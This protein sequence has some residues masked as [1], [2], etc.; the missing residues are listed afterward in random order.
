M[1]L[2][3]AVNG[4]SPCQ[5]VYQKQQ[6]RVSNLNAKFEQNN[7]S[8]KSCARTTGQTARS[9]L[10]SLCNKI[11]DYN[12]LNCGHNA[13]YAASII[14]EE[15]SNKLK[16]VVY[17]HH[18]F[19]KLH[20]DYPDN[21]Q[22]EKGYDYFT[23]AF[24]DF[25]ILRI[26]QENQTSPESAAKLEE[27]LNFRDSKDYNDLKLKDFDYLISKFKQEPE[28]AKKYKQENSAYSTIALL[29][30]RDYD[31]ELIDKL[32]EMK[33]KNPKAL[34]GL[35]RQLISYRIKNNIGP[36]LAHIPEVVDYVK[37]VEIKG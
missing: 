9:E 10:N 6:K 11:Y 4:I 19:P 3:S 12:W 34:E 31:P 17:K 8:F 21:A 25:A 18:H 1:S 35:E 26:V 22:P 32:Y 29:M 13:K 2:I 16:G 15:L 27:Y 36:L 23:R 20:H 37:S 30:A 24:S 7:L 33:Q 28:I 5:N 14:N